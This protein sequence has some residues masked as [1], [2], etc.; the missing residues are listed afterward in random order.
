MRYNF[1]RRI[2]LVTLCLVICF[3]GASYASD[4][5]KWHS[6]EEGKVVA[7]IEKKKVF[8]HF[9]ADWCVF[10]RKMAKETFRDT[11]VVSTLNKDFIA[12]RVDFD[13]ESATAEK[14]GVRGLP[15]NWFLTEMGQPIVSIP[16]Y[17]APEALLSLLKEVNEIKAG[18]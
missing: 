6:Y 15:A 9:Y 11:T 8:L 2:L 5:I 17:I 18:G 10:C 4:S 14:Y 1:F 3:C 12:I 13:E 16:G 7:K